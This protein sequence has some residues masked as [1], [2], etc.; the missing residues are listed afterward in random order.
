VALTAGIV[1]VAS[2]A[3]FVGESTTDPPA[4]VF[5]AIGIIYAPVK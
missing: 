2:L 5:N 3:V 1:T 4:G